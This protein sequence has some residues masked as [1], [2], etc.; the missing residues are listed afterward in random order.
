MTSTRVETRTSTTQKARPTTAADLH[1][2]GDERSSF[3]ALA[4]GVDLHAS[5]DDSQES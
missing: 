1:A 3:L 4:D 2:S 5:G